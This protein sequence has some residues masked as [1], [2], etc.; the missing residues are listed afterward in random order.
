MSQPASNVS[1]RGTVSMTGVLAQSVGFMGPVFSVATLLPLVVGLSATGRGAGV[2]TPVAIVIAGIGIFGAGWIIAQYAKRIHLCG[3]LYEY[4]CDA[5]GSRVG[6]VAGWLY[7]GAMLV[8]AAATFLVLGGMTSDLMSSAFGIEVPWWPLALVFVA[9]VVAVVIIGVQISVRAQLALVLLSSLVILLFSIYI[10]GKGG[11]GG[12]SLSAEP[13]NPMAVAPVDLLYGVLY[14]INMFIGFESAANLAE[15][16]DDPKRHIPR[17]V[18]WSLTIVGIYFVITAYAQAVGFGLDAEAWKTSVFPLQA[19][20]NGSEFGSS[21]FGNVVAVLIIL[22]VLAVAIGVGVAATRGMFAMARAGRLPAQLATLHPRLGTPVVGAAVVGVV[23]VASI[24]LVVAADGV[25]SRATADPAT[26]APQ[27]APMF[28]WMAGFAGTGLAL[29][30]L[31]VSGAG[32]RGLWHEVNR[33]KLVMAAGAGIIVAAGAVFGA[34]Y[35]TP[36][37]S[38]PWALGIWIAAGVAWSLFV[39]RH[40]TAALPMPAMTATEAN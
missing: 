35:K 8:L 33:V 18:L 19:L 9:V 6:V 38:L 30:Y 24:V 4:I 3:S 15:E 21:W 25:F 39:A 13:I 31:V 29:I 27:W 23:A 32:A 34:L 11:H 20:A 37:T 17:A 40:S 5:F 12:H 26:L 28:G 7:Y 22:D 16:T 10:I 14:G 2:A 1:E 36:L